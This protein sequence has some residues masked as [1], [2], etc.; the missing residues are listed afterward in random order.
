M[1]RMFPSFCV[2]SY[3]EA[4][5]F[6]IDWLGFQIDWEYGSPTSPVYSQVSRDGLALHLSV[7][8]DGSFQSNC[9]AHVDDIRAL[10]REWKAKRPDWDGEVY[11]TPWRVLRI[12]LHDPFGN[13][14]AVQQALP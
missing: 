10:H 11:E 2:A 4:V 5:R 8:P 12:D 1:Q 6:Y 13:H 7:Q 3:D 14:I 9:V